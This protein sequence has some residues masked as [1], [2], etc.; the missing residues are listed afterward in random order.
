[1]NES[2]ADPAESAKNVARPRNLDAIFRPRSVALIGVSAKSHNLGRRMLRNILGSEFTGRVYPVHPSARSVSGL[3]AYPTVSAIDDDLDLVIVVVPQGRVLPLVEECGKNGVSALVVITAGFKEI[4]GDGILREREL[5]KA[6]RRHG[7]RMVG[8]NCMGIFS[9]DEAVQLHA[10]F[11]PLT[12]RAGN[13]G[14]V[15]QSGA[16]GVVIL[17]RAQAQGLGFYEFASIGNRPDVSSNDLLERWRDREEVSLILLYLETFGN[18]RRFTRL[19]REISRKKPI[20]AVK[21]GRTREGARAVSS[22]TGVLA[23]LP[24]ATDALFAQCGVIGVESMEELFDLSVAFSRVKRERLPKGS[25]IAIV[26]DAGGPGILATDVAIREKLTLAELSRMT[27]GRLRAAL[28]EAATVENPVDLIAS[29]GPYEYLESLRA[30]LADPLVDGVLVIYVP[31]VM[32]EAL[33]VSRAIFEAASEFQEKPVVACFMGVDELREEIGALPGATVPLYVFPESAVRA[34]AALYRY[35]SYLDKPEEAPPEVAVDEEAASRALASVPEDGWLG[36][37]A[38]AELCAAYGIG[39]APY[40]IAESTDEVLAAAEEIGFPLVL[41]LS[42]PGL[43]HKTD[44]GAVKLDI[45]D[46]GDL[47]ARLKELRDVAKAGQLRAPSFLLQRQLQKGREVIVGIVQDPSFGPVVMFG[48]GGI[49]VE[50]MKDVAFRVPP[51]RL[52]DAEEMVRSI[53]AYPLLAGVRGEAPV[54]LAALQAAVLS[55]ARL[56]MDHP[57]IQ[58]MEVNPLMAMP[59]GAQAVDIRIRVG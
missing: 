52:R 49:Y 22:H 25:R 10:T 35:A 1:M 33:D 5:V 18:P 26:T 45:R 56:A 54:D 11:A 42:A 31:P 24:E 40:R 37:E 48:L 43:L 21:S 34:L 15:T 16:L 50:A 12:P 7:M 55:L 4:G 30:V 17:A 9:T 27:K 32:D 57:E 46:V 44:L 47:V 38:A 8:P 14:F 20:L 6:I 29:A 39:I 13:I 53:K 51:L 19:A 41:K 2:D 23:G 28:P 36:Q 3:R 58:E 59:D